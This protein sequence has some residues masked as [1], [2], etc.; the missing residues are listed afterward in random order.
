MTNCLT[1]SRLAL[2]IFIKNYLGATK[3]PVINNVSIFSN[4]KKAYYGG[5]TEVYK[6]YGQN[7]KY[8]DV[9]SLYPFC[10]K[11]YMPPKAA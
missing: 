8:Y 11:N 1:I 10:S 5:I 2:N 7:L 4:I 3:I 6:P 9:N